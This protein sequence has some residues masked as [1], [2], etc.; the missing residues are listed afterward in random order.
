VICISSIGDYREGLQA[1]IDNVVDCL[2]KFPES[3]RAVITIPNGTTTPDHRNDAEVF[4][5][6]A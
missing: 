6:I 2:T 4:S 3:K 1:K 5:S